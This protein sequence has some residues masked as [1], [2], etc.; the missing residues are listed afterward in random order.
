MTEDSDGGVTPSSRRK[1]KGIR[2]DEE[3]RSMISQTESGRE[4]GELREEG[5]KR[6]RRR[7]RNGRRLRKRDSGFTEKQDVETGWV[8]MMKV[9]EEEGKNNLKR[10][11]QP[12]TCSCSTRALEQTSLATHH[13]F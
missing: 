1:Q 6:S 13:F 12:W 10:A 11:K 5:K 7:G 8:Q 3:R 2:K 4:E 9:Q